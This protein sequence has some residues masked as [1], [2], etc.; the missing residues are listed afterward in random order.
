MDANERNIV[1]VGFMAT[2]KS[3]VGRELARRLGRPFVD[4][5]EEVA[6]RAGMSVAEVF[7]RR[8]EAV[9]RDLESAVI[10]EAAAR[11]GQVIAAGGGALLREEN[12]RRLREGG[13]LVRLLAD[14]EAIVARVVAQG[15]AARPL[16]AAAA[17][18]DLAGRVRD[19]LAARE[20]AYRDADVTVDTTRLTIPE[21]AEEILRHLAPPEEIPVALGDRAYR[22]VVG[23]GILGR[24]G[25]RVAAALGGAVAGRPALI[26]TQPLVN[27][28]YG[29]AVRASLEAAGFAVSVAEVPDGEEAKRLAVAGELYDRCVEAGLDRE[30]P[31]L[32]LG[33]GVVGD[34]AG[35]VA[36]TFLRGLPFVQV[37][38]TLVAQVDAAV[39][40]KVAVN[41]PRAK[42]LIGAFHQPRLCWADVETLQSLPARQ[43]AAGLAEVVKHGVIA[44]R[45]YFEFLERE[46][47]AVLRREGGA[48]IRAVAGS[49][50]IKAAVVQEDEREARR[51][52]VLNFGH[53]VGHGLEAVAGYRGLLHGEAVAVGMAAAGRLALDPAVAAEMAAG[54]PTWTEGEQRRLEALLGALGLPL[55]V[56]DEPLE[57]ILE[58]MSLDKK[59]RSGRIH[60]VLPRALGRVEIV[61]G[62]P[63]ESVRRVLLGLGARPAEPRR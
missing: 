54:G 5:D 39:G 52:M 53:T 2:G 18:G 51:R 21:V 27:E 4:T 46:R 17:E 48:L 36:A 28:L 16:L 22:I 55:R 30:S 41:H 29:E 3:T 8:G 7:A 6:A 25:P 62:V 43:F 38:T 60:W 63:E 42:N 57:G 59:S 15:A 20:P 61:P 9:F 37:P 24:I 10:A 34:L 1:L 50:R 49:C 31:I 33:G 19:L 58:A 35:F 13:V 40:G 23:Q 32:A 14:P 44:D 56:P 11:R 12:R 45:A 26:V 47:E